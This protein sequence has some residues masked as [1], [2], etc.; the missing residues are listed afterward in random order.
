MEFLRDIK[1]VKSTLENAKA[2]GLKVNLLIGAGCSKSAGIPL[3]AEIVREIKSNFRFEHNVHNI[4]DY[5][6][7]MSL[8]TPIERRALIYDYVKNAK[9]NWAHI[10]MAQLLKFGYIN[11]IFTTNFD[12]L[13]TR[14]CSLVGEYPGVY[15]L[16]F[17]NQNA[18]RSDLLYDKSIIHLHGQHTGFVLCNTEDEVQNQASAIE[19]IF[20]ELNRNSVW[21][22]AGYS[23]A[24]DAIF[25]LLSKCDVYENRLFWVG[26]KNNDP[27]EHVASNILT[28]GKYGFYIKGYD[29]DSFFTTLSRELNA[30]PP[31]FIDKPFTYL[32]ER[33]D[34]L[35]DFKVPRQFGALTKGQVKE[36]T[37]SILHYAV[38]SIENDIDIMLNHYICVG[39]YDKFID[40]VRTVKQNYPN[41]SVG[42]I[43]YKCKDNLYRSILDLHTDYESHKLKLENGNGLIDDYYDIADILDSLAGILSSPLP[44]MPC[45]YGF[46]VDDVTH[47]KLY[48]LIEAYMLFGEDAKLLRR[49]IDVSFKACCA[50][51]EQH[52]TE[53]LFDYFYEFSKSYLDDPRNKDVYIDWFIR[54]YRRKYRVAG[55]AKKLDKHGLFC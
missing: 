5:A 27:D 53:L 24:N 13:V 15:D 7:C 10:G 22:I 39:K 34:E 30:F 49:L 42:R 12:N 4:N 43:L 41:E 19:P 46:G 31:I 44:D 28:K 32:E 50:S 3:A 37:N 14:A 35:K 48:W 1:S 8:L 33:L 20:D 47:L 6:K 45:I 23:G 38:N 36:S 52:N 51:K 9:I 21:I 11:R 16:A 2:N 29:A 18:F 40:L 26:F 25:N 54:L 17:A 55:V